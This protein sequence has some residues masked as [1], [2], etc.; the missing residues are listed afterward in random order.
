[1]VYNDF[2]P[3]DK[4][5]DFGFFK[6]IGSALI[7]YAVIAAIAFFCFYKPPPLVY[8]SVSRDECVKVIIGNTTYDCV[9]G[10]PETYEKVWV[11]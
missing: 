3:Y 2:E 9:D 7:I 4:I 5:D 1:M 10:L 11:E 8:W 6:G